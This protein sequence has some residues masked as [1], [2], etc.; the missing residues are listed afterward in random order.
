MLFIF[1][2][3]VFAQKKDDIL[4]K[5]LNPTGEGQIEIYRRGDK[6]FGKLAWI[7]EPNENGK[8]KTDKKNP[9]SNNTSTSSV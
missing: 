3:Q 9:N 7:K 4:G 5:W 8:P 6:F 2:C 1:S